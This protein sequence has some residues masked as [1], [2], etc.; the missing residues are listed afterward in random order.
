LGK[1]I[2]LLRKI[3]SYDGYLAAGGEGHSVCRIGGHDAP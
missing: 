2:E 3:K 1:G